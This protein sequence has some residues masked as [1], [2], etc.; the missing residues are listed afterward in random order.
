MAEIVKMPKLGLTMSFGVITNILVSEGQ[1]V[2]KDDPLFEFETNKL[3]DTIASPVDGYILKICVQIDDEVPITNAVCVIGEQGESFVLEE[4][5]SAKPAGVDIEPK[6]IIAKQNSINVSPIAKK[7]AEERGIDLSL[8]KG[9]GPN[10]RIMKEDIL[11]FRMKQESLDET[12]DI[13]EPISQTRKSIA[14]AMVKSK[15]SI[16]HVYLEINADVTTLVEKRKEYN[17]NHEKVSFNDIILFAAVLALKENMDLNCSFD[18]DKIIKHNS[19]N[20][21]VPVNNTRGL[22]VPVIKNA[23]LM[24]LAQI[25]LNSKKLIEKAKNDKLTIEEITDGTFT[26]SNLGG[27]GIRSFH[28]IINLPESIILAVGEI[29]Q[30]LKLSETGISNAS[31][32]NLSLSL[33][34]RIA[35]GLAGAK[36][37]GKLKE[38]L[39]N[40]TVLFAD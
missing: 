30:E 21:G 1:K 31:K 15:Q 6:Q 14:S 27:F 32:M 26:V 29:Y 17:L 39:E 9:T 37:L 40:P 25:H 5:K 11:A 19:I 2:Q 36:Y 35:D 12:K 28:A 34:H 16:P 38:I 33:D 3:A 24:N 8:I 18:N 22:L 20:L 10:G 23:N 4:E 13:V 7:L